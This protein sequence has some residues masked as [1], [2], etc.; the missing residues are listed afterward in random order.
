MDKASEAGEFIEKLSDLIRRIIAVNNYAA[1]NFYDKFHHIDNDMV[2]LYNVKL[3]T[4]DDAFPGLA[5][6]EVHMQYQGWDEEGG[7]R[8]YEV[9]RQVPISWMAMEPDEIRE[10]ARQAAAW[11]KLSKATRK[12]KELEEREARQRRDYE[13]LKLKYEGDKYVKATEENNKQADSQ[14]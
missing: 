11:W 3:K 6:Y 10:S 4:S 5:Y 2:D 13:R 14:L 12:L 9:N 1:G 7:E 8:I